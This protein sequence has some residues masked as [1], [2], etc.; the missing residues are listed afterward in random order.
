MPPFSDHASWSVHLA[1]QGLISFLTEQ[2]IIAFVS[3]LPTEHKLAA[4]YVYS[5]DVTAA[6]FCMRNSEMAS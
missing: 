3:L 4:S 6:A 5:M 2:A 1:A